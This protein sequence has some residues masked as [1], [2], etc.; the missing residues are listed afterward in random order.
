MKTDN[1]PR[2]SRKLA[3]TSSKKAEGG[4]QGEKKIKSQKAKFKK[5]K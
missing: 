5:Q 1:I 2:T 4:G 3:R